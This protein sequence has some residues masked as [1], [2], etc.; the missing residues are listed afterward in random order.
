MSKF[1]AA[2]LNLPKANSDRSSDRS[3]GTNS[4]A[5]SALF[6]CLVSE[7]HTAALMTAVV[8]S[9]VNSLG[10]PSAVKTAHLASFVAT[11]F[12]LLRSLLLVAV[13]EDGYDGAFGSLGDL[14]SAFSDGQSAFLELEFESHILGA[15]RAAVVHRQNLMAKWAKCHPDPAGNRIVDGRRL[16]QNIYRQSH[17]AVGPARECRA[18]SDTL[19]RRA[20]SY[21]RAVIAPAAAMAAPQCPA[22]VHRHDCRQ[23]DQRVRA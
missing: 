20:R 12:G 16:T 13:Q 7:V 1:N 14:L 11:D 6:E 9:G 3:N 23:N 15:A 8:A 18:R 17:R 4:A 21:F 2:F 10:G 5:T 19:H 22:D